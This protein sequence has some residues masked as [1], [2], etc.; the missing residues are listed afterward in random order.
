MKRIF[1]LAALV[2]P[3][4]FM[5]VTVFA[6]GPSGQKQ[7]KEIV[8]KAEPAKVWALVKDFGA[9][10]KWHPS[11]TSVKTEQKKDDADGETYTFRTVT[12]KD[13]KTLY[14]KQ[15]ETIDEDMK[16]GYK[17]MDG[18]FLVS[19][20]TSVMKVSPGDVA[21]ESKLSWTGRFYNKANTMEAPA[22]EDNVAANKA[23]EDLY[24]AGLE[25][26]KKYLEVK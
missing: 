11:V 13:G 14:E 20:Y 8:I 6:H 25:G 15:R 21:G 23:I 2:L 22:G 12:L 18:T 7:V 16:L 1:T 9:I 5:P 4:A 19:N 26:I 17:M 3:I 24:N 10:D